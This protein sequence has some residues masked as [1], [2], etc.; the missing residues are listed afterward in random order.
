[1][2]KQ[3]K[4]DMTNVIYVPPSRKMLNKLA[5]NTCKK[6]AK[7]RDASYRSVE[8]TEGLVDFINIIADMKAQHLNHKPDKEK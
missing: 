7:E 6:L 3:P 1:M 5:R 8:F 4:G 2:L